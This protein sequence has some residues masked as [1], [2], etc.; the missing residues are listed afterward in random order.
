VIVLDPCGNMEVFLSSSGDEI[1]TLGYRAQSST[2]CKT[3]MIAM[4][5]VKSGLGSSLD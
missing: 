4:L 3:I 5:P 1:T 2:E